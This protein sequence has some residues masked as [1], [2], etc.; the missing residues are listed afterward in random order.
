MTE[1]QFSAVIIDDEKHCIETLRYELERHCP[2]V[3]LIS[4]HQDTLGGLKAINNHKPDIVFLDIELSE[5]SGFDLL[6]SL[7]YLDF[8]LIFTTAYARYAIDAL[9]VKAFDYLLKPVSGKDLRE[10]IDRLKSELVLQDINREG[11]DIVDMSIVEGKVVMP[12]G[13]SSVFMLR[14]EI[15]RVQADGN[16]S[17]VYLKGQKEHYVSKSLKQVEQTLNHPNFLRVHKSHIVN[18]NSVVAY[19]KSEGGRIEMS[20]SSK[21]PISKVSIS[22]I[23]KRIS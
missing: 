7:S 22:D 3:K 20:D 8:K 18:V 5:T 13:N 1:T 15:I 2:E 6:D 9:R 14:D 4:M 16:F 12:V 19:H 23:I 10:C 21:L 11:F 17:I